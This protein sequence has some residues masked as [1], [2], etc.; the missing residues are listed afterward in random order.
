MKRNKKVYNT[1]TT[2]AVCI[3]A[4]GVICQSIGPSSVNDVPMM[5]TVPSLDDVFPE[6]TLIL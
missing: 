6:S 5:D 2:D 3:K 4:E 1:P